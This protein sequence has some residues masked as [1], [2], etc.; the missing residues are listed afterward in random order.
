MKLNLK[1]NV[2]L[3]STK[4]KGNAKM[5]FVSSKLEGQKINK[6]YDRSRWWINGGLFAFSD[7]IIERLTLIKYC[8]WYCDSWKR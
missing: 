5:G 6:K 8:V 4:M 1:F 2:S 3:D 7:L